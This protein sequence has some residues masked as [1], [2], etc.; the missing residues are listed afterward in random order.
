MPDSAIA[1]SA[2]RA[3]ARRDQPRCSNK[4]TP[5]HAQNRSRA[6]RIVASLKAAAFFNP[7]LIKS[8]AVK[9]GGRATDEFYL[10]ANQQNAE[11]NYDGNRGHGDEARQPQ[12]LR[13]GKVK[14][15]RQHS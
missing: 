8:A 13:Q 5:T 14:Q 12:A 2:S 9:E 10:L 7:L 4:I 1:S 6:L 11:R 15:Q 3:A